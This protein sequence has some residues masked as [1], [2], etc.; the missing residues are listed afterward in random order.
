MSTVK[1]SEVSFSFPV[2]G[3][4][5]DGDVWGF[6][7]LDK[8]TLCGPMTLKNDMQSGMELVD[9]KGRAWV[10]R[11]VTRLRRARSLPVSILHLLFAAKIASRIEHELEALPPVGLD[12]VKRRCCEWLDAHPED[13][14][15]FPEDG[16]AEVAKI[17][18][19]LMRLKT[20][21]TM[22]DLLGLDWFAD[23]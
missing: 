21:K 2:L 5:P 11:S 1:T 20:M 23:Y 12:E 19:R 22:P 13:H 3:F 9:A 4:T 18:A 6:P 10:V 15:E 8:L 7:D 17:K 14:V 16:P